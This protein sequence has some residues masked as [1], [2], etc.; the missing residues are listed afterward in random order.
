MG[1]GTGLY[2][3]RSLGQKRM[4]ESITRLEMFIPHTNKRP[5]R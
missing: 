1:N 2:F 3:P 4:V 5:K